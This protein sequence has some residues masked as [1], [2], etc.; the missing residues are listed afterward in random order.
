[1]RITSS[2][3]FAILNHL[4]TPIKGFYGLDFTKKL[5]RRGDNVYD[6]I[7]GLNLHA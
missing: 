6:L 2:K 5:H 3:L 4:C 1:M 7:G